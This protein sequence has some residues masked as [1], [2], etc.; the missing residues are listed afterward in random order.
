MIARSLAVL[1]LAIPDRNGLH[2]LHTTLTE[3]SYQS[4]A[5]V[6]LSVR[7]FADDFGAAARAGRRSS[8]SQSDSLAFHYLKQ[9]SII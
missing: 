1:A 9:S 4:P 3:V 8:Q 6:T 2:P 7:A 5:G